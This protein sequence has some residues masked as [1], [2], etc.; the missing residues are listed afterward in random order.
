MP[1]NLS[2]REKR[3]PGYARIVL[4]FDTI[5]LPQYQAHVVLLNG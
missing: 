4:R 2:R 1:G 5:E 3:R